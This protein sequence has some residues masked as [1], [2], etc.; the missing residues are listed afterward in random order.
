MTSCGKASR[1]APASRSPLARCLSLAALS[2]NVSVHRRAQ[3]SH[4]VARGQEVF[5]VQVKVTDTSAT[6]ATS[7]ISA[8]SAAALFSISPSGT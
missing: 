7:T 4:G 5:G 8:T 3:P 6:F 2:A 1:S